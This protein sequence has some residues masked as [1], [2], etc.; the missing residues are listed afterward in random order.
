MSNLPIDNTHDFQ[1]FSGVLGGIETLVL[2]RTADK[3]LSLFPQTGEDS[4]RMVSNF[5]RIIETIEFSPSEAVFQ[6]ILLVTSF[7]HYV[8]DFIPLSDVVITK[9]T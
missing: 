3:Y 9:S 5:Q 7:S 2:V 4:D 1:I 6:D 8:T